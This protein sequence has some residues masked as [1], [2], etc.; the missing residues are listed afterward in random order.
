ML[1]HKAR[2]CEK[3]NGEKQSLSSKNSQSS[4]E[5]SIGWMTTKQANLNHKDTLK[6]LYG[7]SLKRNDHL[8]LCKSQK[9]SSGQR[10]GKGRGKR[11]CAVSIFSPIHEI[12]EMGAC[13]VK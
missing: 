1:K 13:E 4:K 8:F 7:S 10:W 2:C 6:V 5:L 9:L 3:C 11:K 12:L